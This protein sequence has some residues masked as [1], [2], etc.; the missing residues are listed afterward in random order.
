MKM[1]HQR[2]LNIYV[3]NL[4][5]FFFLYSRKLFLD[6]SKSIVNAGLIYNLSSFTNCDI[7]HLLRSDWSNMAL[8]QVSHTHVILFLFLIGFIY[9]GMYF[10]I[11][12]SPIQIFHQ[13]FLHQKTHLLE[14]SNIMALCRSCTDI[15]SIYI[16]LL[17]QS[18]TNFYKQWVFYIGGMF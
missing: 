10:I 9:F 13:F 5:I 6:L 7:L 14:L 8:M 15:W 12:V 17:Y 2:L 1:Q 16:F 11:D 3:T 4:E 18:P